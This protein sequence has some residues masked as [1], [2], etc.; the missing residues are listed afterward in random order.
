MS[1]SM[2]KQKT[3]QQPHFAACVDQVQG[4]RVSKQSRTAPKQI[5]THGARGE[6]SRFKPWNLSVG[7]VQA[8]RP[9]PEILESRQSCTRQINGLNQ[10]L[11]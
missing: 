10:P 5:S 1:G 4:F 9:L 11:E 8:S 7:L 6:G 3:A 2:E